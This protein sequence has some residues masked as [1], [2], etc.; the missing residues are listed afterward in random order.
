[1]VGRS[2]GMVGL[3]AMVAAGACSP[4]APADGAGDAGQGGAVSVTTAAP[5][6]AAEAPPV[7]PATAPTAAD[8]STADRL[9]A[10]PGLWA[11]EALACNSGEAIRFT[12]SEFMTEGDGGTWT[13]AGDVLTLRSDGSQSDGMDDGGGEGSA[14]DSGPTETNVTLVEASAERMVWRDFAGQERTFVR[15]TP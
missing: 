13:L 3:L 4:P 6:S 14:E 11:G 2:I 1:M 15:C 8:P 10:I 7:P 12:A 9:A 5:P